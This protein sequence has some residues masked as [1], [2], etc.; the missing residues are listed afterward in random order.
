[1]KKQHT[2]S[3]SILKTIITIF[4][5]M[6][7]IHSLTA[8]SIAAMFSTTA[9]AQVD[10]YKDYREVYRD[11]V[12][13]V[14]PTQT[15]VVRDT[16]FTG[17]HI[18]TN[19]PLDNWFVF[20]TGGVHTFFGDY[21]NYGA[22]SGTLSPDFGIGLGKW[23]TPDFG[24]KAEFIRS[25]SRGYT[26]PDRG[27]RYGDIMKNTRGQQY[28]K[29]KTNW[30]DLSINGMFNL[31]RLIYGYEG[32]NSPRL[33]NQFIVN[34]GIGGVHHMGL[35]GTGSDNEWSGHAELQY[36]RF[37][38]K[39][40][41]FS[42]DIK[43][44]A[45]VYQTNFDL[46]YGN[47]D[48]AANKFDANVG[49]D[50]GFTYYI[51]SKHRNSWSQTG[52][53]IY[54]RDYRERKI[55]VVK[56]KEG[57]A[58]VKYNTMT[59]YV[60]YPNNYSG[61]NDAPIVANAPVNAIDYL[62]GG[63]YTQKKFSDNAAVT[64]LLNRDARTNGLAFVDIPT[65]PANKDFAINY[66]PRGYEMSDKALSLSLQPDEMI[67][68][69]RRAGYFYAP[70][71]DGNNAWQYRIDNE[72]WK[73]R[74]ASEDNYKETNSYQ[75]NAHAGLGTI[76]Q[77][78]KVDKSDEFVSFADVYAAMTS[79]NGYIAKYA[80][81][82]TVAR[83]KNILENGTITM[84]QAEGLATSQD[85]FSG[86]D[87]AQVG[88]MRNNALSHNRANTVISW[89]KSKERLQQ[90]SSQIFL[91]S[92]L[93]GAIREVKD[94]STRGLNAKLNRCVKVRIHYMLPQ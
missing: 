69:Q 66:V 4:F 90:V 72:T 16:V 91:V 52:A 53:T 17:Q 22:F 93:D 94:A 31:S 8:L 3:T 55:E 80:D 58:P 61:R 30:W 43:A 37:F 51:G 24:F 68:F 39:K 50:L 9:M 81:A 47:R 67:S 29:M 28:R 65:E 60:F 78:L 83:I 2:P 64:A 56:V 25:N 44:R 36:S 92:S 21:S 62:A 85:N 87:A 12:D 57:V 10:K 88:W 27:Y 11:T 76:R 77:Y 46:E 54:E 49:I 1:M 40:K 13:V 89:L 71:F 14:S 48:K 63:I 82:G 84:I 26:L 34:L 79:N 23:V 45:L 38:T 33:M 75:L 74:L 70:I 73:Q 20:A 19:G 86:A 41:N 18:M 15:R 59:F 5:T 42:F 7:K 32:Y 6:K 35:K